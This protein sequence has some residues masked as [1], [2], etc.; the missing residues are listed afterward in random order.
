MDGQEKVQLAKHEK[1]SNYFLSKKLGEIIYEEKQ[2]FYRKFSLKEVP[3]SVLAGNVYISSKIISS[4]M[5][6]L[7]IESMQNS[8]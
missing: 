2:L 1:F 5:L 3:C 8:N 6:R 4:S 7:L